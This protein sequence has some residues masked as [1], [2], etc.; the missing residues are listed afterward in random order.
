MRR[1]NAWQRP[2][3]Y[4]Y[5]TAMTALVT[6]FASKL[7]EKDIW[8]NQRFTI[9]VISTLAF[10]ILLTAL[11]KSVENIY[12][13]AIV[14][15]VIVI[16]TVLMM[17]ISYEFRPV[18]AIF[19]II[20]L[21]IGLDTGLV[22]V[23]CISVAV[24][25]LYGAEQEYLYGTLIIGAVSC[26]AAANVKNRLKFI[27]STIVFVFAGFFVNGIFQYYNTNQ[28]DYKFAMLSLV[29]IAVSIIIF[30]NVRIFTRPGNVQP[31]IGA[32]SEV[33]AELKEK[34]LPLYY[35]SVEVAELAAAGAAAADCDRKLAYAGGM[36][37]D[38]GKTRGAKDYVKSGLIM[39]NEYGMPKEI[40]AVIVEHSAKHRLPSSKE[41]AI[42]MLA[43]SV[44]SSI[45][46]LKASDREISEKKI[47]DN[48]FN[49]RLS[50]GALDKSQLTVKELS[51]I[52]A[53]F[54]GFYSVQDDKQENTERA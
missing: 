54:M 30:V 7:W 40:K 27:I 12:R 13:L 16:S 4:I 6:Y 25:F 45:E 36:L 20:T 47:I 42:V 38:I 28:F 24:S 18:M 31:Y 34:S 23:L 19:M 8:E 53:A 48:V 3:L 49:V 37:H 14:Y 32:D 2:A 15:H 10:G 39:A 21:F 9:V 50:G 43:D 41:S 33:T 51:G 26:F 29:S 52:R 35:H 46:Y 11:S 1:N 5:M 22:S 44:I 17:M